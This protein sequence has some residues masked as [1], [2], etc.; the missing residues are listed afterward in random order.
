MRHYNSKR[1]SPT[2]LVTRSRSRYSSSGIACLRL[3]P[4]RSL[5]V[6]TEIR[7]RSTFSFRPRIS[8]FRRSS[9]RME[10]HPVQPN[11]NLLAHQELQDFLDCGRRRGGDSASRG[12]SG[13]W[14]NDARRAC[15]ERVANPSF[16]RR[17]RD[18][19]PARAERS[20]PMTRP[21]FIKS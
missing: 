14:R 4:Y 3:S 17:E 8:D 10:R 12:S 21:A 9:A 19:L 13:G 18:S 2:R 20:R 7:G 11:D 15:I 5:N 6:A 1:E 16:L